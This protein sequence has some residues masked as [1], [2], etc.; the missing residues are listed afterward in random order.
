MIEPKAAMLSFK[1]TL[2]FLTA[3][4]INKEAVFLI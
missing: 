1:L 4:E 3:I 2:A